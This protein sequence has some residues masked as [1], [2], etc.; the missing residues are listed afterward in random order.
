MTS[1]MNLRSMTRMVQ[2][3]CIALRVRLLNRAITAIYDDALRKAGL[4]VNQFSMLTVVSRI[5]HPTAKDVSGFLLM[6]PSTASRNLE[7]MRKEGWI[8]GTPGE[9]ARY[10]KLT[11]T[12]KGLRLLEKAH[13]AWRKAQQKAEQLLGEQNS[14]S[15]KKV[16]GDILPRVHSF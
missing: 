9:D 5:K 3:E 2:S 16:V 10:Q 7:R 15:L 1:K 12:D 4:T 14:V 13:P 6:D 11:L 8:K